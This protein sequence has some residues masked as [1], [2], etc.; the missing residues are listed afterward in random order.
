MARPSST[1]FY[2]SEALRAAAGDALRPGG[3]ELTERAVAFC[4]FPPG[5]RVAD[6]GCGIGATA[7]GLRR[8]HGLAAFGL[9][10]SDA[11]LR[12]ARLRHPGLPLLM[13]KAGC[14]PFGNGCLSAIFC[15]CVLSLLEDP[16]AV[17][18]E[19]N[20]VLAPGGFLVIADLYLREAGLAQANAASTGRSCR[21]GADSREAFLLRLHRNGFA[22]RLWEDHSGALKLLAARLV[23]SRGTGGGEGLPWACPGLPSQARPGYFLSVS[24]KAGNP[25]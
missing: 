12:R 22:L 18:Q 2:A 11:M 9:E 4:S 24:R 20:R 7:D 10:P 19:F 13:G 21:Q 17:W 1:P 23:W 3:L 25:R 8:R 15:E 14:L 5:A 6:I 16:E